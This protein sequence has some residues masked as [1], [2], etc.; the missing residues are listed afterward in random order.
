M[1]DFKLIHTTADGYHI[2]AGSTGDTKPANAQAKDRL[3]YENLSE[4]E[5]SGTQWVNISTN[6]ASHVETQAGSVNAYGSHIETWTESVLG[7]AKDTNN[8]IIYTSPDISWC[9][10]VTIHCLVGTVDVE[11]SLDYGSTWFATTVKTITTAG[12]IVDP[13]T[14]IA[15]GER[16]TLTREVNGLFTNIRVLNVGSVANTNAQIIYGA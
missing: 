6:G 14:Q 8:E 12:V 4:E 15:F 16:G 2:Y 13:D 7:I 9:K 5:Y 11:I 10:T 3:I 1:A